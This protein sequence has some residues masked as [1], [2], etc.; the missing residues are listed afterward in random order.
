M[1]EKGI[2]LVTW[3]HQ[4]QLPAVKSIDYVMAIWLQPWMKKNGA[5]DVLYHNNGTVTECPRAN[6]FLV[7]EDGR[8]VTPAENILEGVTRKK[9]LDLEKYLQRGRANYNTAGCMAG[10]RSIYYQHY[11]KYFTSVT[12]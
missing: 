11:K 9:L 7:M 10:T 12:D 6:F 5:D 8:L 1:F 2:E 4:R 3:P